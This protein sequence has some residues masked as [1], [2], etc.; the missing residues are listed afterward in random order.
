[1]NPLPTVPPVVSLREVR[2]DD[3]PALFEHQCDPEGVRMAAFPS[4]D[5][6]A[7]MAHWGKIMANP[8][9]AIRAIL[10]DGRIAGHIA[11]WSDGADRYLG[12]WIGRE[13][14]GRGVASAGLAQFLH[15]ETTRPLMAHVV[16]HNGA[17]IRVLQKN[18]FIL[19][20]TSPVDP[21]EGAGEELTFKL[22]A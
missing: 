1:M 16:K 12:Y 7:F 6:E 11:A 22:L 9:C 17:S 20:D 8:G 21:P 2:A 15:Y 13:F 14:W 3:L 5:R 19:A 10:C 18:G 4:R